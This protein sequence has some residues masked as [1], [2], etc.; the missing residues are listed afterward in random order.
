MT[1]ESR[2]F[3]VGVIGTITTGLMMTPSFNDLHGAIEFIMGHPVWTHEFST[4]VPRC[5]E[6]IK[7]HY[8][9]IPT[10]EPADYRECL[11]QLARD[12]P[13][14]ITLPKGQEKRTKG[15]VATLKT[16][17]MKDA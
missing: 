1:I 5:V 14:G 8:P 3:D 9:K 12:Y 11:A 13:D 16:L 10:E 4:A 17:L 7:E 15:P 6:L 2:T